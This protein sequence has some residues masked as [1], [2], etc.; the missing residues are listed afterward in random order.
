MPLKINKH[1][2]KL[3]KLKEMKKQVLLV[4]DQA[5][6]RKLLSHYLG[7]FYEVTEKATAEEALEW[8]AEGNTP[9]AIVTDIIMPEMTGIEFL[10]H[11]QRS[12][13]DVPPVL[14]LSSVE[15]SVEKMKCFNLGA[16]DY[17]IKPFNPEELRFRLHNIFRN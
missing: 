11:L 14:V 8:M 6:T 7:E 10:T 12:Q 17:I 1:T 5:A 9:D 16:L 4:E 13:N 15:N 2:N 3:I